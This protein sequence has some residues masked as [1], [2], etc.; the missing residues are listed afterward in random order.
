[1]SQKYGML[2]L[3]GAHFS[4]CHDFEHRALQVAFCAGKAFL[5]CCYISIRTNKSDL[6]SPAFASL[7][8]LYPKLFA[9]LKQS[10]HISLEASQT[11][12]DLEGV[13]AVWAPGSC[14]SSSCS[15]SL[16]R[17]E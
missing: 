9:S 6:V 3:R 13:S 14:V 17:R 10:S 5:T 1:M 2:L 4:G 7:R 12:L 16:G 15:Q 8:V 11:S